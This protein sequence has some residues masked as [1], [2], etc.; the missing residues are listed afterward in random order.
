MT[1]K[2]DDVDELTKQKCTSDTRQKWINFYEL[3]KQIEIEWMEKQHLVDVVFDT[4][5]CLPLIPAIPKRVCIYSDRNFSEIQ[6]L[7]YNEKEIYYIFS[8]QV[9]FSILYSTFYSN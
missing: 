9:D 6:L 4:L 8:K 7:S 5:W 2:N 3:V 1:F